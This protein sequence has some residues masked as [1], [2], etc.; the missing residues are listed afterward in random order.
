VQGTIEIVRFESNDVITDLK[1]SDCE[2][3]AFAT[4]YCPDTLNILELPPNPNIYITPNPTKNEL[5]IAFDI[6]GNTQPVSMILCNEQ[7]QIL[8]TILPETYYSTG[9]YN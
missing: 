7:G 9:T 8:E 4:L 3:C 1:L 6:T 2:K 5:N